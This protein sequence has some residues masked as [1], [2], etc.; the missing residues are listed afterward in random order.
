MIAHFVAVHNT[1]VWQ[2]QGRDRWLKEEIDNWSGM[3][4]N[5]RRQR[6]EHP[7]ESG[8]GCAADLLWV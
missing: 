7:E 8:R 1:P 6:D 4:L 2:G 3:P 5:S